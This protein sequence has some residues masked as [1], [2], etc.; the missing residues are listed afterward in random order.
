QDTGPGLTAG[1]IEHIFEPFARGGSGSGSTAAAPGAGLGL[2]I[3]KMLTALMGGELTVSS[4]PGVGSVF[5]VKLFLPEVHG[6]ALGKA[7]APAAL[8]AHG[9]R[10]R[11]GYAGER[12]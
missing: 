6:D 1:E 11:K 4:T 3:A 9:Q 2:T 5:Q 12:R 10:Q 8:A 7:A